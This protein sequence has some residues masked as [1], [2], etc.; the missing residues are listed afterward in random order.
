MDILNADLALQNEYD[1]WKKAK[2]NSKKKKR[3]VKK[4]KK[5]NYDDEAG[6]HF[7]AYVPIDGKVWRIDGLQRQPVNLGELPMIRNFPKIYLT[8]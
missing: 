6:F 7:I 5:S 4:S 2:T 1:K 3:T 8:Q